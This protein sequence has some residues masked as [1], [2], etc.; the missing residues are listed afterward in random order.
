MTPPPSDRGVRS[1]RLKLLLIAAVF[2]APMLAAGLLTLSG[3][4]PGTKGHGEP[5]LPQRNFA[6]EALPV[7]LNDG[8]AYAWRDAK[9]RMTLVALTGSDCA[10]PCLRQLEA[11]AKARVMLNRNQPRL[12]LLLVGTPPAGQTVTGNRLQLGANPDASYLV[13]HD[14]SGKL[15]AFAPATPDGVS[16]LLVES[17]G[18]AL[19]LYPSGFDAA[20]LAQDLQKVIR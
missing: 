2:A 20:G 10:A 16:A 9:P 6:D 4:Q 12:R 7:T 11:I 1:S 13:G 8:T 3:W 5:I 17:N 18:T 19:S 14:A 15:A